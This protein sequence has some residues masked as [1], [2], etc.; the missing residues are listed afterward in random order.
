MDFK[1]QL[2]CKM[3]LGVNNVY[4]VNRSLAYVFMLI[5]CGSSLKQDT[6]D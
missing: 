3:N 6:A 2:Q 4:R 1:G 5:E